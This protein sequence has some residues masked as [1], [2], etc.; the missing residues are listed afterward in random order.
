LASSLA[1]ND[2]Y[3]DMLGLVKETPNFNEVVDR[4][5][6]LSKP[7]TI[8]ALF[9]LFLRGVIKD[10]W[11]FS[12]RFLSTESAHALHQ[13]VEESNFLLAELSNAAKVEDIESWESILSGSNEILS[14]ELG[15][16]FYIGN[17]S[18]FLE[19]IMRSAVLRKPVR[20]NALSRFEH[21]WPA[22]FV[23]YVHDALSHGLVYILFE[24]FN[25]R[26]QSQEFSRVRL[27]MEDLRSAKN[28]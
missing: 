28:G 6:R 27:L 16:G 24:L 23:E 7:Y 11:G 20:K 25:R 8:R 2:F 10:T 17:E 21:S 13:V 4:T 3:R 18:F 19:N 15:V 9:E 26:F 22:T 5:S 14:R 1:N 12:G